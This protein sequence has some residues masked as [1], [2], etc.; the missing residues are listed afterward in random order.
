VQ[1]IGP[2]ANGEEILAR[3]TIAPYIEWLEDRLLPVPPGGSS[4][5]PLPQAGAEPRAEEESAL[6]GA[7]VEEPQK[8]RTPGM[9]WEGL[10]RRAFALDVFSCVRCGGRRRVL[11]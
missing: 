3:A 5:G 6:V 4:P 9:D 10:L 8:E 1:L 11:A 2:F 7:R